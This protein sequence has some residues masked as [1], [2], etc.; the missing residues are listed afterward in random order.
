MYYQITQFWIIS[1]APKQ[2]AVGVLL[3]VVKTNGKY[4]WNQFTPLTLQRSRT[5]EIKSF[6]LLN[7]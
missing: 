6:K 1:T 3:S 2:G 4:L 5:L 7:E